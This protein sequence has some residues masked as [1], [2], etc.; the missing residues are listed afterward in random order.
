MTSVDTSQFTEKNDLA[1]LKAT[2]YQLDI[3]KLKNVPSGLDTLK[4]KVDKLDVGTYS[5][6]FK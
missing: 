2:V 6:C 4:S 3:G 1:S 5:F